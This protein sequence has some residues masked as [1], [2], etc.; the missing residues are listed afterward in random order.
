MEALIVSLASAALY[1][2]L[3]SLIS[4]ISKAIRARRQ[5]RQLERYYQSLLA[6]DRDIV[7]G[8]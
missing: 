3:N 2:L 4:S 5:E 8:V 6:S 7:I 1:G